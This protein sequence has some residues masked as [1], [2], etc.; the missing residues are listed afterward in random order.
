MATNKVKN[1]MN[2]KMGKSS[3]VKAALKLKNNFA[4]LSGK[5]NTPLP[6]PKVNMLSLVKKLAAKKFK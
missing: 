6:K 1:I 4:G 2:M 5:G 3:A